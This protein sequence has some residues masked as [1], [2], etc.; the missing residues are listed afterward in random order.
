MIR[1]VSMSSPRSGSAGPRTCA[2]RSTANE[3]LRAGKLPD[4]DD[5]A[6][7]R[8]RGHHRRTHE[9]RASGRTALASLEVPVRRGGADLAPFETVGIDRQAHRAAGAAP[10]EAGVEEPAIE[11]LALVR[12]TDRLRPGDHQRLHVSRDAMPP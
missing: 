5:L 3:H 1:S 6:G 7:D 4:V 9:K 12:L 11:P 10:P 8:R 2:M